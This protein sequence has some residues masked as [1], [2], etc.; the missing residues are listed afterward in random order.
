MKLSIDVILPSGILNGL[1][2]KSSYS[3]ACLSLVPIVIEVA[4][5]LMSYV[6]GTYPYIGVADMHIETKL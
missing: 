3:R 6:I 2:Y 4:T 5:N 1:Y